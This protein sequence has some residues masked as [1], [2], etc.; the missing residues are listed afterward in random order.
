MEKPKFN[1]KSIPLKKNSNGE[2]IGHLINCMGVTKMYMITTDSY[3]V[4]KQC[5]HFLENTHCHLYCLAKQLTVEEGKL[6]GFGSY[7]LQEYESTDPLE[8]FKGLKSYIESQR[9][10]AYK[11]ADHTIT[12]E[13]NSIL[14]NVNNFIYHVQQMK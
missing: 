12:S 3:V 7:S 2:F 10:N 13:I 6:S 5:H 11:D 9:E 14:K 4:H 8:Y 1:L